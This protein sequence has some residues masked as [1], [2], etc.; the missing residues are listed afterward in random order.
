MREREGLV[1]R[2]RHLRRVAAAAEKPQAGPAVNPEAA[3][4]DAL[5]AR[6]AH[7]ESLVEGLQDSVHREAERHSRMIAE[8]Q[9]QVQPAAMSAAL[10]KNARERGL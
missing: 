6:I 1:A 2:I 8:L 3:R 10:S 5:E 7:M 4:F 9:A